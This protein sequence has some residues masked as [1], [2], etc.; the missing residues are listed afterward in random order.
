MTLPSR[1]DLLALASGAGVAL[2]FGRPLA[3]QS[4]SPAALTAREAEVQL[5]P[6]AYPATRI[7]GYDGG[8]RRAGA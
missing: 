4:A 8:S 3:A 1:R 2:A 5:A 6:P 7:W